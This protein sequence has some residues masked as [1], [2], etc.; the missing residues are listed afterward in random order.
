MDEDK[1]AMTTYMIIALSFVVGIV[2][3]VVGVEVY[4]RIRYKRDGEWPW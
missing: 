1:D 2:L 4:G 3:V